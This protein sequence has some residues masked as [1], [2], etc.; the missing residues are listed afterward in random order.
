M[1]D[2]VKLH[3]HDKLKTPICIYFSSTRCI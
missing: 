1:I 2:I 3:K